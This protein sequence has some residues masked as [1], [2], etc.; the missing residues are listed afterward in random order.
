MDVYT[1]NTIAENILSQVDEEGH[2]QMMLDEII[3]H[4]THRNPVPKSQ[5]T[6]KTKTS[7]LRKRKTTVGWELLV[8]WKDGTTNWV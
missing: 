6:F 3:D 2:Q 8:Q 7:T 4:R 1:A 5:G